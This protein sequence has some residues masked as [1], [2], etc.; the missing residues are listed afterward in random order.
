MYIISLN[1]NTDAE[2]LEKLKV[3]YTLLELDTLGD[4][5]A[6]CI[7]D[8]E[9]VPLMEIP[10]IENQKE[11]HASF[12]AE[13]NKGNTKFCQDAYEHLIG[14]WGGQVD[15]FYEAVLNRIT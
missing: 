7:I 8:A 14:R 15:T 6:W 2:A 12:I 10:L 4:Y 1:K 9:K 11:L 5:V 3:K 13:Y